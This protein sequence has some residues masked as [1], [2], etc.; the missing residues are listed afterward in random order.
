MSEE[1]THEQACGWLALLW[2]MVERGTPVTLL[3]LLALG[4]VTLWHQ[5]AEVDR[6]HTSQSELVHLLL[7][8]K[9]KQVQLALRVGVCEGKGMQGAPP[10]PPGSLPTRMRVR[11]AQEPLA[12][13]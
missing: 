12:C 7:A 2:P 4:G 5:R 6:L 9:E 13:W 10:L 11:P 8:E 1:S 3:L